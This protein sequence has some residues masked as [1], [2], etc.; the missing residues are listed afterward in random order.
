[1]W[2]TVALYGTGAVVTVAVIY[3]A[4]RMIR[5]EARRVGGDSEARE[6][7]ERM[8]EMDHRSHEM[9]GRSIPLSK[10]EQLSRL[11]SLQA[12]LSRHQD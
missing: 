4:F 11:R 5:R 1:V 10:H 3:I 7:L 2:Q 9:D 12:R 6:T 8:V